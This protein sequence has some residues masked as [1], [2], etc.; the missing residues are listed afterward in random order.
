MGALIRGGVL[1]AGVDMP[2][3]RRVQVPSRLSIT[4]RGRPRFLLSANVDTYLTFLLHCAHSRSFGEWGAWVIVCVFPQS[5][6]LNVLQATQ[7]CDLWLAS[8][9]QLVFMQ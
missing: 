8:F 5:E 4:L 9:G 7:Y 3:T 2:S 6:H 1:S